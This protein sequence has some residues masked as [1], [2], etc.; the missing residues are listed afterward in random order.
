MYRRS[1]SLAHRAIDSTT[2][3][4]DPI[5]HDTARRDAQR[6]G[7]GA[8]AEAP[9]PTTPHATPH[10]TP[11][12]DGVRTVRREH[13]RAYSGHNVPTSP[14]EGSGTVW[15]LALWVC[16]AAWALRESLSSV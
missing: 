8:Q 6:A 16:L 9:P 15:L 5:R 13:A 14:V 11:I 2:D 1:H 10:A 4:T 12:A 3:T 7:A